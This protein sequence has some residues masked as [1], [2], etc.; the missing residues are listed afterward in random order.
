M[1]LITPSLISDKYKITSSVAKKVIKYFSASG[2]ILPLDA[3]SKQ[4]P[5]F[6]G[7]E[8]KE[9]VKEESAN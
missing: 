8:K 7:S 4:L 9:L 1:R 2:K 5:L 3:Q 6:T